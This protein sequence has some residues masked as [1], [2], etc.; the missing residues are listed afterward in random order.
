MQ[1]AAAEVFKESKFAEAIQAYQK[2]E[3]YC[4][5]ALLHVNLDVEQEDEVHRQL[6]LCLLSRSLCHF[7]LNQFE[8]SSRCCAQVIDDNVSPQPIKLKALI[9]RGQCFARTA[10]KKNVEH[11]KQLLDSAM[12]C[13]NT[14]E[15]WLIDDPSLSRDL[16]RSVKLLQK[17]VSEQQALKIDYSKGLKTLPEYPSAQQSSPVASNQHSS[18]IPTPKRVYDSD[19]SSDD[20]FASAA[21]NTATSARRVA[22]SL[23][24]DDISH[25]EDVYKSPYALSRQR[26]A[27]FPGIRNEGATCWGNCILQVIFHLRQLRVRLRQVAVQILQAGSPES[28]LVVFL[29]SVFDAMDRATAAPGD[30]AFDSV[31]ALRLWRACETNVR[32]FSLTSQAE[33]CVMPC[34]GAETE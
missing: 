29:I 9:R 7:N 11:K 18:R 33:H 17:D 23:Y 22:T 24:P 8:D 34:S 4:K 30:E 2:T 32:V 28:Q 12:Q 19:T 16:L 5:L 14:A 10:A 15:K 25:S 3:M 21:R 6:S 20:D 27:R 1:D 31:S 13:A 26:L